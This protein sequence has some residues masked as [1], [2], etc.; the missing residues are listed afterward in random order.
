MFFFEMAYSLKIF[1]FK[2]SSD[3]KCLENPV[4]ILLKNDCLK[5]ANGREEMNFHVFLRYD[6]LKI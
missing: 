6:M 4:N 3:E 2:Y 5:Y 1:L